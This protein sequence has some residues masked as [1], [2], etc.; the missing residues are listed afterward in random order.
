[1]V[2]GVAESTA[3]ILKLFGG[4]VSDRVG[5]R[6]ALAVWGYGLA[7]LSRP[8]IALA[9]RP[10][11]V[12]A[13][14]FSDRVGKGIR[15][16]PRDA[17]LAESVPEAHRG[18]AFGVHRAADHAGA[19]IGPLL[20][21]A[22]LWLLPGRMRLVF[23]LAAIPGI[24][25]V[26][27]V[28]LATRDVPPPA[29]PRDAP[30]ISLRA[31]GPVF[32]RYLAVVVLFTLGHASDAFLLLQ[33]RRLGVAVALIPVLWAVFHVSKMAWSVPGG[34]LA[35]RLGPRRVITVGWTLYAVVYLGFAVATSEW[36]VWALF[37]AYGAFFGLTESPERA[38]VAS[39]APTEARA[40][41]FGTFHFAVGI[42][43]LPASVLFGWLWER[44]SPAAAFGVGAG[45]AL[46]A[47]VGLA[48]GV[49]SGERV[50]G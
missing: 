14:R 2:E 12:L 26:L 46:A 24:A 31:L 6:K 28:A 39:L 9:T 50:S 34:V 35:D 48:V 7:S 22:L 1:V 38:L 47:A 3:S 32:P 36:H 44:Y 8:L 18:A 23:A 11:H 29:R 49:G 45:L 13:V 43:A 5:R 40:R 41:A 37:L 16:A 17:L 42:A 10:W 15:S 4:W 19:V 33:A 21:T 20:A 27:L 30:E 25:A